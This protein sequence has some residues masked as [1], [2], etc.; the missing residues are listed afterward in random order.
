MSVSH[1]QGAVTPP[2]RIST[3]V[4]CHDHR[5]WRSLAAAIASLRSQAQLEAE[6]IVA[7]DNNR[8]LYDRLRM[9]DLADRLV[10]N[11]GPQGASTTRNAGAAA[12]TSSII[13]FLDDDA[14]ADERWLATL[15]SAFEDEDVAGVGG[16]VSP[17]WQGERPAWFPDEFGWV[18]GASFTGMPSDTAVVR[19]VWAENMAIRRDVFE[20]IEGFRTTF[21]KVGSVSQPED[22][23]LCMRS[24]AAFPRMRWIYEPRAI[25]HHEVPVQR[26]SFR[27]FLK[28]CQ[29]EGRGKAHL[30]HVLRAHGTTDGRLDDENRYVTAVLPKSAIGYLRTSL[31]DPANLL[32]LGALALGISSAA[33]GY[34]RGTL[35]PVLAAPGL[36]APPMHVQ[37][38]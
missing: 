8:D 14:R 6:V 38:S 16:L 21:G 33:V 24:T 22:T 7:V 4:A 9:A 10:L 11:E 31:D 27:F 20:A 12:A 35:S 28:R 34:L 17:A 5:R 29:N 13:A 2:L 25:V 23:E 26:A 1:D 37:W 18:V 36:P 15:I 30:A 32:R 19:N 3:V